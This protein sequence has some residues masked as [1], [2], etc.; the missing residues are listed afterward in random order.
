MHRRLMDDDEIQISGT[1]HFHN[2]LADP[3]SGTEGTI[4]RRDG[5]PGFRFCAPGVIGQRSMGK[6]HIRRRQHQPAQGPPD[7]QAEHA[8]PGSADSALAGCANGALP[9]IGLPTR[10]CAARL[11]G[12]VHGVREQQARAAVRA[13]SLSWVPAWPMRP[14]ELLIHAS[15]AVNTLATAMIDTLTPLLR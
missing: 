4:L 2:R 3:L 15:T 14:Q 8:A 12:G 13:A 9:E 7:R 10:S 6:Q 1:Q 5:H 11:S